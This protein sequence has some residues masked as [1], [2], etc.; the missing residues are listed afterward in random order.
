MKEFIPE[1][2][3]LTLGRMIW[4]PVVWTAEDIVDSLSGRRDVLTPPRKLRCMVGPFGDA[5]LYTANAEVILQQYFKDLCGLEP[6]EDVLDLGCGCGGLAA[7]LTKYLAASS[8][9]EGFDIGASLI[10]WCR[11]NITPK[12]PNFHFLLA[13]VFNRAYNRHGKYRASEYKFPYSGESFDFAF[14]NSLFTH[15]L[16]EDMENYLSETARVLKSGGRCL[17]TFFLLNEESLESIKAGRGFL[18]F[19]YDFGKY[20]TINPNIPEDAICY[21]EAFVLGL[22]AKHGL[23]I[24]KPIHYGSWSWWA[25]AHFL[26]PFPAQDVIVAFKNRL[27]TLCTGKTR[28]RPHTAL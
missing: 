13:D 17:I 12:Y 7:P 26:P 16:P 15:M 28:S 22:Y 6:N 21:D 25:S 4:R 27:T 24:K 23:A 18:D 5:R 14:A 10:E 8:T 1:R 11:K 2:V 9:Y 3:R 19:K 20:R